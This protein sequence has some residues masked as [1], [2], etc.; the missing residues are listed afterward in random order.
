[1]CVEFVRLDPRL[2]GFNP[3][4]RRYQMAR[5]I[6][7]PP[8]KPR[9]IR[10]SIRPLADGIDGRRL[11]AVSRRTAHGA[12]R[13]LSE[14]VKRTIADLTPGTTTAAQVFAQ[15]VPVV[16][17]PSPRCRRINSMRF[18]DVGERHRA[19]G[20]MTW[21]ANIDNVTSFNGDDSEAVS[22]RSNNINDHR[23]PTSEGVYVDGARLD[24]PP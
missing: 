9:P 22:P 1:M 13:G 2:A 12:R 20:S 15:L 7:G 8:P 4:R 3:P 16:L 24:H 14:A 19:D 11:V 5:K 6:T 10:Q 21:H 23:T 17:F 18:I